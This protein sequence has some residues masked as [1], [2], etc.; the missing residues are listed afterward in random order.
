[1]TLLIAACAPQTESGLINQTSPIASLA[2][3][4]SI[5]SKTSTVTPVIA[6]TGVS[7]KTPLATLSDDEKGLYIRKQIQN[8][9]G[10]N[11]PCILGIDPQNNENM[12]RELMKDF[13]ERVN[14]RYEEYNE[15]V[16]VEYNNQSEEGLIDIGFT[17]YFNKKL[18]NLVLQN[19]EYNPNKYDFHYGSLDFDYYAID[20]ILSKYGKPTEVRVGAWYLEPMSDQ[21]FEPFT[22][23]LY[24]P[25]KGFL[26]EYYGQ[27]KN[28]SDKKW[29]L[30]PW[31][32]H[33]YITSWDPDETLTIKQ[34]GMGTGDTWSPYNLDYF[35]PIQE[36][37]G[38]SVDEFYNL[39]KD[40]STQ[41]C[42]ETDATLWTEFR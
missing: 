22:I 29:D 36:A 37:S 21:Y 25:E 15:S 34:L 27:N 20:N 2:E 38:I 30:C 31:Q 9:G 33:I 19:Y 3:E 1:M 41:T 10:C 13:G 17:Y 26:I 16:G 23:S 42:I 7:N 35:K 18:L 6:E 5:S 39:F 24:Y 14:L 40:G 8:N 28:N 32:V 4:T 11:L 12:L